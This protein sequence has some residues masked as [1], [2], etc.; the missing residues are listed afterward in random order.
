MHLSSYRSTEKIENTTYIWASFVYGT[1][2]R[3]TNKSTFT[4]TYVKFFG[5]HYIS[6]L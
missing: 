1:N 4:V 3:K 2:H 5:T 6:T